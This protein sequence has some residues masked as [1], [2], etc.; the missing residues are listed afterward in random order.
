MLNIFYRALVANRKWNVRVFNYIR[1]SVLSQLSVVDP[2]PYNSNQVTKIEANTR[3]Q[4]ILFLNSAWFIKKFSSIQSLK[5]KQLRNLQHDVARQ[6]CHLVQMTNLTSLT[7]HGAR[8]SDSEFQWFSNLRQLNQLHLIATPTN[9]LDWIPSAVKS[10]LL[11][12]RL[13]HNAEHLNKLTGL[14]QLDIFQCGYFSDDDL[15]YLSSLKFL[16]KIT[17]DGT[18]FSDEGVKKICHYGLTKL[19]KLRLIQDTVTAEGFQYFTILTSLNDIGVCLPEESM[20]YLAQ[21]TTLTRICLHSVCASMKT[22]ITHLRKLTKLKSL[23]IRTHDEADIEPFV[24]LISKL[25]KLYDLRLDCCDKMN[26]GHLNCLATLTKL[27]SLHLGLTKPLNITKKG[28][29][30]LSLLTNLQYFEYSSSEDM[31]TAVL[32]YFFP[33]LTIKRDSCISL[34]SFMIL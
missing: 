26:D 13:E 6:I 7:L 20:Q 28:F 29:E 10:L 27:T 16:E 5:L 15:Q 23:G 33:T 24:L 32:K 18:Y 30:C 12:I 8:F 17:F 9:S 19:T 31:D 21:L 25:T 3:E 14:R 4:S 34:D 11:A 22:E 2:Q 1:Q